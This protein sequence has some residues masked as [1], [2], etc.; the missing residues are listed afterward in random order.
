V[1]KDAESSGVFLPLDSAFFMSEELSGVNGDTANQENGGVSS[2][3][4]EKHVVSAVTPE[5]IS[6]N[7][8]Y[9]I[10]CIKK[11]PAGS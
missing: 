4:T 7:L 1:R 10:S 5:S 6:E 3:V 2:G 11:L 8:L 9:F